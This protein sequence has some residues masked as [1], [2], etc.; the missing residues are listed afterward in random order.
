MRRKEREMDESFGKKVIDNSQYG[1]LSLKDKDEVYSIPLSIVR[2]EDVLYFHCAKEGKKN[3]LIEDGKK[4]RAV[5]VSH[6]EVPEL[7]T[8]EEIREHLKKGEIKGQTVVRKIFTTEYA[9]SIVEGSIY[10]VTENDEKIR[11]LKVLCEKY[12][13]DMMEFFEKAVEASLRNTDVYKVNIDS[14]TS[15]RNKVSVD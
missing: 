9:S 5:F 7:F 1:V 4:V 8:V 14:I 6:A 3:D 11:A 12:N 2:F 13:P 10:K 15:K